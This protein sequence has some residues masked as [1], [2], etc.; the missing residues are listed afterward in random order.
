[1]GLFFRRNSTNK[2]V[3]R[4]NFKVYTSPDSLYTIGRDVQKIANNTDKTLEILHKHTDEIEAINKR[5][6]KHEEIIN[7]LKENN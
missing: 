7:T 4:N 1:M 2:S 6:D 5:L 3:N